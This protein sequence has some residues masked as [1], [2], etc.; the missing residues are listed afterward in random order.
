[1]KR[2]NYFKSHL[3]WQ[4]EFDHKYACWAVNHRGWAKCKKAN[5][6]LAKTR[7]KRAWQGEASRAI[8]S[9]KEESEM[10]DDEL[11][12]IRGMFEYG[13]FTESEMTEDEASEILF[14]CKGSGSTVPRRFRRPE[15]FAELYNEYMK[16]RMNGAF[17]LKDFALETAKENHGS[18]ISVNALR[19]NVKN[20][21]CVFIDYEGAVY[22]PDGVLDWFELYEIVSPE[23][24]CLGYMWIRQRDKEV[25]EF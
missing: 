17:L 11:E 25:Y 12:F 21:E 19:T 6:K 5:K 20:G 22:A 15:R 2:Q 4:S 10:N 8:M 18:G 13:M 24:D 14:A 9:E 3:P 1:M 23:G 7:E 16:S